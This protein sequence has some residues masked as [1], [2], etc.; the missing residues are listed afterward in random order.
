VA[1]QLG[2]VGETQLPPR[3]SWSTNRVEARKIFL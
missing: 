1:V 2:L 3:L